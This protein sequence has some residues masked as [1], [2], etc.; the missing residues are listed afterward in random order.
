MHIKVSAW[1]QLRNFL[2]VN[3]SFL[4]QS[5]QILR[6]MVLATEACVQYATKTANNGS[7]ASKIKTK[8]PI[9]KH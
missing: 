4:E 1:M 5:K 7:Y 8:S 2:G 3:G 6:T 9:G